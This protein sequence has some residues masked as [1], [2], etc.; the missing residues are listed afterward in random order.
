[1]HEQQEDDWKMEPIFNSEVS[2]VTKIDYLKI[3]GRAD[4]T[5]V[6]EF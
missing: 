2:S 3:S 4:P 5:K 1:M 6:I